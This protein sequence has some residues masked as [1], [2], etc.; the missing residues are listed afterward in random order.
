VILRPQPRKITPDHS[1]L[2]V[3][4]LDGNSTIASR[5]STS[6]LKSRGNV[7][8]P[9]RAD[10]SRVDEND[11]DLSSMN[12]NTVYK[13]ALDFL[14][15]PHDPN[16]TQGPLRSIIIAEEYMLAAN[17]KIVTVAELEQWPDFKARRVKNLTIGRP[18]YGK[19]QFLEDID[20]SAGINFS[21][22]VQIEKKS[23]EVYP[24]GYE[25][26]PP[27]GVELNKH[28]R[29]T[30]ESVYPND[31]LTKEPIT[32][33]SKL[34]AFEAKVKRSTEEDGGTF[35]SYDKNSGTWVFEVE[36]FSRYGLDSDDDSDDNDTA[37]NES[38]SSSTPARPLESKGSKVAIIKKPSTDRSFSS[39][40]DDDSKENVS[41]IAS[42]ASKGAK[43]PP[44]PINDLNDWAMPLTP[45]AP[46]F[47]TNS[48][49]KLV[50]HLNLERVPFA[51]MRASLF[52][53]PVAPVT[54]H[55]I[56]ETAAFSTADSTSLDYPSTLSRPDLS[57]FE[58][59]YKSSP[60]SMNFN[61]STINDGSKKKAVYFSPKS[62]ADQSVS[63][64]ASTL[65]GAIHS[66]LS[67]AAMSTLRPHVRAAKSKEPIIPSSL[68]LPFKIN[69]LG[70][71]G[72]KV[73]AN[74]M[75]AKTFRVG[76]GPNGVLIIP[77][78]KSPSIISLHQLSTSP[79]LHSQTR[80]QKTICSEHLE[81]LVDSC[82]QAEFAHSS[83]DEIETSLFESPSR[84]FQL[85]SKQ[86]ISIIHD[87]RDRIDRFS[88]EYRGPRSNIDSKHPLFHSKLHS[89]VFGLLDALLKEPSFRGAY[90]VDQFRK[91][92]VSSWL[93]KTLSSSTSYSNTTVRQESN[94]ADDIA[95]LSAIFSALTVHNVAEAVRIAVSKKVMMKSVFSL[96][97]LHQ[98][99]IYL[100]LSTCD[101]FVSAGRT[102]L[103]ETSSETTVG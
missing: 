67:A 85:E 77:S 55:A 100:G 45:A 78:R 48:T 19:V 42:L 102:A 66:Q 32:D 51:S 44:P 11:R 26:K 95:E 86:N 92:Q 41:A 5:I 93:T 3:R 58:T 64:K 31:K 15:P 12:A 54:S 62:V 23:V 21:E 89:I 30:L 74:L 9:P 14:Q 68:P 39:M 46:S 53:G 50:S 60:K 63:K 6:P 88:N 82:L 7:A 17:G 25:N 56:Q 59:A 97:C 28:A 1:H 79:Y 47:D 24:E 52:D 101:A 103:T 36:H 4:D 13:T 40:S 83:V 33:P 2:S 49:A 99:F 43:L 10:N 38:E 16:Q 73:D 80:F 27:V 90:P 65:G 37:A 57:K 29:I 69:D 84:F 18:G 87:L 61:I 35:I 91:E 70:E 71:R 75:Y 76:W 8:S 22:I 98:L 20:L 34:D 72:S 81:P 94:A 96:L